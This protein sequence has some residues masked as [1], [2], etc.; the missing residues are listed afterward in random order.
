VAGWDLA[1][2]NQWTAAVPKLVDGDTLAHTDLHG[3]Q[4]RVSDD[5]TV[6]V[7][8]WGFPGAAARWVDSAFMVIRLIEAGHG[9]GE[10]E[11]WARSLSC[12]SGVDGHTLT[13][14]SVYLAGMWTYWAVANGGP[15]KRHRARL[16][17]E[18]AA[19]RLG[20]KPAL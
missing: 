15:G 6:H 8:D 4:F 1:E 19:R 3:D 14:F 20:M 11:A 5:G 7:I 13:A 17:R 18:Y 9:P 10:A 2:A 16:A 12:L